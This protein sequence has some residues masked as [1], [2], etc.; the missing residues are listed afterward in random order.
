MKISKKSYWK[1]LEQLT[2]DPDFVKN[3]E[4]EF[5]Q[6]L[7]MKDAYGDNTQPEE[8]APKSTSRRDFL[9][10]MGF[11]VAAVSLAA[12][13]TPVKK[14]IPY[15]NAPE[16]MVPTIPNYY[17]STFSLDGEYASVLVKTREGRP[18]YI[19]PNKFAE[20][21]GGV[22]TRA[23]SSV[24][25]LYD[26]EKVRFATKAGEKTEWKKLDDEVK[27]ALASAGKVTIVSNTIISPS[28]EAVITKFKAKYANVTHV[29]Y[30]AISQSAKLKA[31]K[32]NFGKEVIP[33]YHF[34]KVKVVVG[35]GADFLQDTRNA[36][37]YAKTRRVSKEKTDMSRHYQFESLY[38]MTGGNADYRTPIKPSQEGLVAAHLYNMVA[39]SAGMQTIEGLPKIDIAHLEK[40]AKDLKNAKS[41][42]IVISGSNDPNV[43]MIVNA[44]NQALGN[45]G[46]TLEL[47]APSHLAKGNDAKMAQ[48]VD[49]LAKGSIGAVI[50]YNCNPV[51]DHPMGDKIAEG[52]KK[53]KLSVATSDRLDETASL[54][55]YNAPDRHYLESW[56]DYE[57]RTGFF[58]VA[59]PTIRP[60]FDTRQVQD[61]LLVWADQKGDYKNFMKGFWKD[62]LFAKQA[63]YNNFN[64]FWNRL[65]H[66][67]I[68]QTTG[69]I[70]Y[71]VPATI[72]TAITADIDSVAQV[73][74]PQSNQQAQNSQEE[75]V[76]SRTVYTSSAEG[77]FNWADIAAAIK[78]TYKADN[79]GLE[80][81]LYHAPAMGSGA[82]A[83]NPWVQETPDP[84]TKLAWGH[85]ILISPDKA[86]EMD[87]VV[88]E[89]NTKQVTLKV[90]GVEATLPAVILPGLPNN[91]IGLALGYGRGKEAGKIAT[92]AGGV[93]AFKM[94]SLK[95]NALHYAVTEGVELS[96]AN[97]TT[98]I[99]LTQTHN[100]Y[101]GRETIIQE[102]LL[103]DYRDIARFKE[104][105]YD[106][107]I[108]TSKGAMDPEDIS[109][110][111][112]NG[113]W[114]GD[115]DKNKPGAKA[116]AENKK[117]LTE[118]EKE[119]WLKKH[120]LKADKH[121][122]PIHHWGMVVDLNTCTGCSACISACSLENNVPIVGKEEVIRRRDMHWIRIDRYFSSESNTPSDYKGLKKVAEN[123]EVVFQPMMCQH[124]NNAPCETVCPVAA[125]THSSEGLNQMTYN[126]C[127]GTKYCA[128]NCPYKVRRFNWFKY[129]QNNDFDYYMNNDI[130]RMVLN[131]DVTVRSRGVMEKCSMCI[132][133]IQEGKLRARRERRKLE[134][135]EVQV[136]C[137]S[138]CPTD[139]IT[140][141]DLN[142]P[143]SK[144]VKLLEP[145]L[146]ER[147][148]NVLKEINVRP[149]VWYLTK[150]RNK[151][152]ADRF[153]SKEAQTEKTEA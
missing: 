135:G 6:Y 5:P 147:A 145:E 100:T 97:E 126:R 118:A 119:I 59:Q 94:V 134:D 103:E 45:Y 82:M 46:H 144:I 102:A 58:S 68:F 15:L 99:A 52:I 109:L 42:S 92:E 137:A 41:K 61:S 70:T 124:C 3:A 132:Q 23:I 89:I 79:E 10:L 40:C 83:N 85:A 96:T 22:S 60:I 29:T 121:L 50:F 91:T 149:N 72:P 65:L 133:R 54:C 39:G 53:A 146:G 78:K 64:D 86:K 93:N 88:K 127:V 120:P 90:G 69:K 105:R 4:K 33:S 131:P 152:E 7:A 122:Y 130:G 51:Y 87:I 32:T 31:N 116:R 117:E 115:R 55:T 148:Y 12:C 71:K 9:K 150:I 123:P 101:L 81:V 108:E 80:L 17:A 48:F 140:F 141:G 139:A 62:N 75:E 2:N 16:E 63:E 13:E 34:D 35:L 26:N 27:A 11:S 19:E 43:Q 74:T 1:G 25:S 73:G 38:S 36:A 114:Y 44:I 14:A 76:E 37:A 110:W 66:D 136:A 95:D 20:G 21:E 57:P 49:D 18:I 8:E 24:L 138:A 112:I 30:D 129:H 106:P 47:D 98:K 143:E 153:H 128:N 107:Q 28:T 113:D 104:M 56:N 84:M 111:D 125:T 67:G 142:N 151:D 77:N